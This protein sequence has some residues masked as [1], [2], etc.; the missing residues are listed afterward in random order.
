MK[1]KF[2]NY[3]I[4]KVCKCR[5]YSTKALIGHS[6]LEFCLQLRYTSTADVHS[7]LTQNVAEK[8]QTEMQRIIYV[9]M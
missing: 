7:K 2:P 5:H 6:Y 9:G 4:K 8:Y 1:N 3:S